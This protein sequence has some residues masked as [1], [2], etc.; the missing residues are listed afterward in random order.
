MTRL[1]QWAGHVRRLPIHPQWLLPP[2]RP[3]EALG[4][5][6]GKVLD[7]GC[8]DRWIERHCGE[9][10]RYIGLDYPATG[11]RLY[12]ATPD[13]FADAACLPLLDRSIDAVL[14]FEVLEHVRDHRRALREFSRVLK[15]DGVLLMSIPFMYPVHD[16]PHD[17]QRLTEYGIRRDL[18]DAGFEITRFSRSGHSVRAAGLLYCLAL[19]GGLHEKQRWFDYLRLPVIAVGILIVNLMSLALSAVLPDWGA[20]STGYEVAARKIHCAPHSATTEAAASATELRNS[21]SPQ[22]T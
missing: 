14:C 2:R 15:S 11:A 12:A 4:Y 19:A 18:A 7:V 5:L 3:A 8:A 1:R 21:E 20:L 6:R 17:Y 16:A 13:L 10:A 22:Q 9:E